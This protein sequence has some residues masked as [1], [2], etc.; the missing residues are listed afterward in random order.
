MDLFNPDELSRKLKLLADYHNFQLENFYQVKPIPYEQVFAELQAYAKRLKPLI[1]D[2]MMLLTDYHQRGENL[3][4]EGAQGSL[5]DVDLGTYPYVT[6]SNTTAGAA[7]TGTGIGPRYIHEVLGVTKAYT[8]R[9]GGGPFPTELQDKNGQI[10][11]ERGH[12]FGATTG[13]PRRCGWFDVVFMCRSIQAN[14]LTGIVLT[15]IDVLDTFE[16][17]RICTGYRYQGKVLQ[18]PPLDGFA[19]TECEP[20]YEEMPGW[21]ESTFGITNYNAMPQ[22]ARDYIKRIEALCQVPVTIVSTGPERDQT[23]VLQ[24]PFAAEEKLEKQFVQE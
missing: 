22:K 20:I 15:K 21:Q 11:A 14:S 17:I 1:A 5:L 6:S 19:L 8:T 23:I 16:T 3:L 12:E 10:M 7:S 2:I 9:V 18:L 24:D 13:R 4:F